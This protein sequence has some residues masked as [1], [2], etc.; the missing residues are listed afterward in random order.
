MIRRHWFFL[1]ILTIFSFWSIKIIF[2]PGMMQTH[3]G[4]WQVQRAS[5]MFD[6][7]KSGQFPARWASSPDNGYGI[8]LFNFIYPAPYYL[9]AP[10]MFLGIVNITSIKIVTIFAYFLGGFGIYYLFRKHRI[11]A[12]ATAI[13]YILNPYQ[14]VNIFVRGALGETLVIGLAPWVV[15]SAMA[16]KDRRLR[17]YDPIAFALA[18]ISH[19]F[20]GLLLGAI[21]LFYGI[22]LGVWKRALLFVL[23]SIGL[24]SFFLVPMIIERKDLLSSATSNFTYIWSDHFIYPKQLI[25]SK[26]DYWYSMP[27]DLQDGMTFQLG[28][29]NLVVLALYTGW[30][31]VRF[32]KMSAKN[33]LQYGFWP[34]MAFGLMLAM[35]PAGRFIWELFPILQTMQF[36][37]RLLGLMTVVVGVM[38][39]LLLTKRISHHRLSG[40]LLLLALVLL[41]L[42][43]TRNYHRPMRIMTSEEFRV[44]NEVFADKTTTSLRAEVVPKWAS[45]E[46][47]QPLSLR[48]FNPRLGMLSGNAEINSATDNPGDLRF[49]AT[50]ENERAT[51]I[52]Y[53][54]YYPIW[55]ATIDGKP[56]AISPTDSGEISIPL[57][58]GIHDY[59]IYLHNTKAASVG[60]W[61]SL[62]SLAVV[63]TMATIER[64]AKS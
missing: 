8:P 52:Y 17:W 19:N 26:W 40:L 63:I 45:I 4:L 56:L 31:L 62:L 54:N 46:R 61:V 57:T 3:D 34:L 10:F 59:H 43:N 18:L 33:K 16:L 28:F 15:A 25:Y 35:I 37:W 29:A 39:G 64:K 60:N 36:P 2:A 5:I 48:L 13:L 27:G 1:T 11:V 58:Q 41:S 24:A 50:A 38:T 49:K 30:Y 20:L 55:Q 6:T 22:A 51:A 47:Y 12:L 32:R 7:L 42:V 23:L 9:A 14:F 44:T 21:V 53:R